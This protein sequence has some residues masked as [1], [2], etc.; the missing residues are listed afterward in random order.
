VVFVLGPPRSGTSAIS[1]ALISLGI[2]FG[3]PE[4][5]I[6]PALYAHNTKGFFELVWINELNDEI[7]SS[8]GSSWVSY[9]FRGEQAFAGLRFDQYRE[10]IRTAVLKEWGENSLL[11]GIKDPRISLLFPLWESALHSLGYEPKCIVALRNPIGFAESQAKLTPS[12]SRARLLLEWVRHTLSAI[13]FARKSDSMIVD[14]DD[15]ISDPGAVIQS[16]VNWLDLRQDRIEAAAAVIDKN[17]YHHSNSEIAACND[18]VDTLY[19][20]LKPRALNLKDARSATSFYENLVNLWP[21]LKSLALDNEDQLVV[22]ERAVAASNDAL[23]ELREQLAKKQEEVDRSRLDLQQQTLQARLREEEMLS[24]QQELLLQ[25]QLLLSQQQQQFLREQ[26]LILREQQLILRE[27]Q[28]LK[29]V[30]EIE[31]ELARIKHTLGWRLLTYYGKLKYRYLLPIYN[32][33]GR[34]KRRLAGVGP[35]ASEPRPQVPSSQGGSMVSQP[36]R[37]PEAEE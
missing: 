11:I 15:L 5:F 31:S 23:H 18:F 22:L 24:R 25:Q 26:Q 36:S 13:Y 16:I 28:L 37:L 20:S 29:K 2:D 30:D 7:F 10:T 32:L 14:Y 19:A 12:W 17:L 4:H 21:L 9:E 3:N 6:D 27:Q 34:L 33:A 35:P 1:S 8:M